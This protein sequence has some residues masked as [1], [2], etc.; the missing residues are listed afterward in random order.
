MTILYQKN[1]N[2][3]TMQGLIIQCAQCARAHK[4]PITLEVPPPGKRENCH[5]KVCHCGVAKVY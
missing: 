1:R 3:R 5:A 4:D 2:D